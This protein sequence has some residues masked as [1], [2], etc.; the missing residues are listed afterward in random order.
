MSIETSIDALCREFD[1]EDKRADE[2]AKPTLPDPVEEVAAVEPEEPVAQDP[3]SFL[4]EET[5]E[6]VHALPDEEEDENGGHGPSVADL[7]KK[8][9]EESREITKLEAEVKMKTMTQRYDLE[10]KAY[11]KAQL[12]SLISD[13]RTV[14]DVIESQLKIGTNPHLFD[15]YA[16]LSKVVADN[17]MRLAKIDQMVTD[18]K[19]V[20]D[21]GNGNIKQDVI[22]EQQEAAAAAGQGGG[23]TYIQN[24]LCFASD[25]ILKLV[26]KVLPPQEKVKLEDLPKFDLS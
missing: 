16:T 24:N 7:K 5:G 10:D 2:K 11:M 19:V 6:L 22:K 23:N 14:M 1:I 18:Y 21:K 20:E 12:K 8:A 25:E 17:V 26:K 15:T 3:M 13:N 4:E 9:Q